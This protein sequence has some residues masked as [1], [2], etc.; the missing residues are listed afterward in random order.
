MKIEVTV[1]IDP[2][3]LRPWLTELVREV[4]AQTGK[5]HIEHVSDEPIIV[6]PKKRRSRARI[7][8]IT[9]DPGLPLEGADK[10]WGFPFGVD[11]TMFVP[12]ACEH[13]GI[14]HD[15]LDRR[16]AAGK[17]RKGK[18]PGGKNVVCIRSM[19]IYK[20]SMEL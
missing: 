14:S 7:E 5:P 13:L 18:H 17:L 10:Q 16:V 15:T 12:D 8:P 11:G 9:I 3:Q 1:E 19:N 20:A 2:E 4:L 6:R